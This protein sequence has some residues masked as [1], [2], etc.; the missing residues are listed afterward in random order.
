MPAKFYYNSPANK[1]TT[2][3]HKIMARNW[4]KVVNFVRLLTKDDMSDK[5]KDLG[6][7][8]R[9]LL[10]NI[11][12]EL[13]E[14]P[15]AVV[16]QLSSTV[17]LLQLTQIEVN[18]FQPRT[19]FDKNALQ[20]LADSIKVLGVIQPLTVRRLENDKYQLIAGE[21]RLRAAKLAGLSEVPAYVRVANDQEMLE[22]AL[23][24]NIQREDLNPIEVAI[25]Y[26]R[27][28]DECSLTHEAMSARLGK[29]RPVITNFV[30]LLK[31]PPEIQL[32][33]KERALTM[34]HAKVLVGVEELPLQLTIYNEI[35][36]KDLSVRDTEELV[37]QYTVKGT[38]KAKVAEKMEPQ[39][40]A[41]QTNLKNYLG[42][43]VALK[44]SKQGTGQI[45]IHFSGDEDLNRILDLI[46]K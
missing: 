10:S 36:A 26:R 3:K 21:R 15:K 20:D 37:R 39:Y 13:K 1:T 44:L 33:L 46:E 23:V 34:G 43:K 2:I 9:A 42:A 19:D 28:M 38:Q 5:K 32:G 14:N 11:D 17:I 6:K 29:S 25:T 41:V 22:M 18:P 31:L 27:L 45:V 24:E 40:A 12:E 35:I 4:S 30:R 8:I 7:G 16:E